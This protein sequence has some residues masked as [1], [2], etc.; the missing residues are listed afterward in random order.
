MILSVLQNVSRIP[1]VYAAYSRLLFFQ[2]D[3][4]GAVVHG[5]SFGMYGTPFPYLTYPP[6]KP[7]AASKPE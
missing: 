5:T 3:I 7:A 2:V 6:T 1:C 4:L